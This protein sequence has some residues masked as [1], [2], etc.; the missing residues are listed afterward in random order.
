MDDLDRIL[1][2]ES[3]IEP[4]SGFAET[5]MDAV[6]AEAARPAPIPFP[7]RRLLPGL[8][9]SCV[10]LVV[11]AILATRAGAPMLRLPPIDPEAIAR[12]AV[13]SGIPWALAALA[14]SWLIVRLALRRAE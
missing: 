1:A 7:W 5:V 12:A 8:A 2:G 3:G 13:A 9:L 11:A 4:S 6:R 10:L 14:G